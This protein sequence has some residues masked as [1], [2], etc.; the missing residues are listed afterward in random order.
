[1]MLLYK[2]RYLPRFWLYVQFR[3]V[4]IFQNR[5]TLYSYDSITYFKDIPGTK[6]PPN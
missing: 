6:M 4:V 5:Y 2:N 1:M 3:K